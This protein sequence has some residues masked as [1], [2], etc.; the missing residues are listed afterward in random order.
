MKAPFFE[1]LVGGEFRPTRRNETIA[2]PFW[3]GIRPFFQARIVIRSP[4]ATKRRLDQRFV[5]ADKA[6]RLH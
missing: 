1:L 5:V 6:S 2:V 3:M 4:A